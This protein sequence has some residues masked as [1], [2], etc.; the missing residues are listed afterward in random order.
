MGVVNFTSVFSSLKCIKCNHKSN[1]LKNRLKVF[2]GRRTGDK[3]FD[4]EFEKGK[5]NVM[6]NMKQLNGCFTTFYQNTSYQIH[7]N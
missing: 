1:K 5:Y 6:F 7:L 2:A 4:A 3:N